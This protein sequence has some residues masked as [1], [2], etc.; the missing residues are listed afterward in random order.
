MNNVILGEKIFETPWK[1]VKF[2]RANGYTNEGYV[3]LIV[4]DTYWVSQN[5]TPETMGL[6]QNWEVHKNEI[7]KYEN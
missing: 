5:R 6:A 7:V 1:R 3:Y 2:K 4:G